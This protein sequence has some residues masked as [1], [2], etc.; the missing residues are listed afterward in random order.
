MNTQEEEK[1]TSNMT[2]GEAVEAIKNGKA[3]Q[4][5][6]WNGKGMYIFLE[7]HFQYLIPAGFF[8]GRQKK[9]ESVICMFTAQ[10]TTQPGWL[11]SQSDILSE[12]WQIVQID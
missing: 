1:K 8:K 6:G 2:F 9:Y 11:A 7:D 4:R 5:V 3:V 10:G 12:D